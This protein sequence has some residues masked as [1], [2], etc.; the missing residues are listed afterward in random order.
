M[1]TPTRGK[2]AGSIEYLFLIVVVVGILLTVGITA[3]STQSAQSVQA[4]KAWWAAE[5]DAQRRRDAEADRAKVR[6]ERCTGWAMAIQHAALSPMP[7]IERHPTLQ[8]FHKALLWTANT[9]ARRAAL[10]PRWPKMVAAVSEA[11]RG[12]R[13]LDNLVLMTFALCSLI[14][15]S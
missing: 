8:Q 11:R 6:N 5:L 3:Y 2:L 14:S 12:T 4:D 10:T 9:P 15:E 1:N 7:K 13:P